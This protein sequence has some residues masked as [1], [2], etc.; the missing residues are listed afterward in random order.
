[1]YT[2]MQRAAITLPQ[3]ALV[4]LF[5]QTIG[6][7]SPDK[8]DTYC[9]RAIVAWDPGRGELSVDTTNS[10]YAARASWTAD[11]ETSDTTRWGPDNPDYIE[12][13]S[14]HIDLGDAKQIKKIFTPQSASR[15]GDPVVVALDDDRTVLTLAARDAWTGKPTVRSVI[16]LI[17]RLDWDVTVDKIIR[18][19][20]AGEP[21]PAGMVWYGSAAIA[22]G[23]A[24]KAGPAAV[25][26]TPLI[27]AARGVG[28]DDI[29]DI[30]YSVARLTTGSDDDPPRMVA[31]C[32]SPRRREPIPVPATA[33][34]STGMDVDI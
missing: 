20:R 12:P 6:F 17:E 22:L 7:A 28:E 30:R 5:A 8:K 18:G 4:R 10:L 3:H 11:D 23:A 13:W 2:L 9:H 19:G 14:A 21:D 33:H 26:F 16:P 24:V 1:M 32:R 31:V 29:Q 25:T 34:T 27:V 15:A